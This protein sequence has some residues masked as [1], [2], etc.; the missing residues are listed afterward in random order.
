[1]PVFWI[2]LPL[3]P[4]YA[5]AAIQ[6]RTLRASALVRELESLLQ[7]RYNDINQVVMHQTACARQLIHASHYH[8]K[9]F[10]SDAQKKGL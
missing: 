5:I 10:G 1:M 4:I 8:M 7:S 6:K 3:N 9:G 2:W